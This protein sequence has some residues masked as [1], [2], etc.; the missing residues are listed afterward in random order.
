MTDNLS[1]VTSVE[2]ADKLEQTPQEEDIIKSL[3][4]ID[5]A[6]ASMF[7]GAIRVLKVEYNP[8]RFSHSANSIREITSVISGRDKKKKK[9]TK[10]EE[11]KV[12]VVDKAFKKILPKMPV[13]IDKAEKK[14][15]IDYI[16]REFN[17]IKEMLVRGR[18][19][20]RTKIATLLETNHPGYPEKLINE[21]TNKWIKCNDYFTGKCVHHGDKEVDVNEFMSKWQDF[22]DCL[23]LTLKKFF[24]DDVPIIDS[25][26]K[27]KEPP[28]Q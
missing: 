20:L 25:L 12:G 3:N 9:L 23:S 2:V 15:E 22:K 24:E 17:K 14:R 8:E 10:D 19:T 13:P 7:I 28:S 21:H 6:L 11:K 5:S 27:M 26:L 16:T 18:Q 1:P 4:R